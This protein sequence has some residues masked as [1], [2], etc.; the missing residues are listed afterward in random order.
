VGGHPA[1][2]HEYPHM[3]IIGYG[4]TTEDKDDWKCSGSL[5]SERW[6]LTAA[7]CYKVV[8]L[9]RWARLG[10]LDIVSQTD[11][12]RPADYAIV[13]HVL[14]PNYKISQR[15]NDIALFRLEK[16]VE[17]SAYV[18]PICLNVHQYKNPTQ[19][20]ATGWGRTSTDGSQSNILIE[21]TLDVFPADVCDEKYS[22]TYDPK[23]KYGILSDSMICA[24]SNNDD[25]DT[26]SG[27]SGGPLQTKNIENRDTY[28]Q[29]GVTSFG[30][31][32]GNKE[33]PGV[34]TRVSKYVPWIEEIVWPNNI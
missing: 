14:H 7:H 11:D 6:I 26:C 30:S 19:Q 1:K 29:F 13:Q 31:F 25:K 24:G 3:A 28:T 4:V 5:I 33:L 20:V 10:D 18:R 34:Y 12:A 21:I 16:D 17:L 27:D 15:Y 2:P 9:A 8:T 22:L 32:C 23:L